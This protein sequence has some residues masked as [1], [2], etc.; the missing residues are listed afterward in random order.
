MSNLFDLSSA[1]L[2]RA[3]AIK[4]KISAL[5][6]ELVSILG[7]PAPAA[8]PVAAPK[9]K[10]TMSA[11]GLARIKAAQKARWAK[12]KSATVKVTVKAP[13]P[14]A[15]KKFKMSTAA[16]AKISAAA[17]ARWAKIKGEKKA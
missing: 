13:A 1:Q 2:I 7:S 11:A 9:K 8:K 10:R 15:K 4:E 5:E 12:I 6:K 14:V 3:A 17:K 16:K